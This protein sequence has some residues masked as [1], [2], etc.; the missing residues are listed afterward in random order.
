M[1]IRS[2]TPEDIPNIVEL[3]RLSLGERLMPK[4]IEFWNWKH[5]LNPFGTSKVLIAIDGTMIIGVRAFM[6]WHWSKENRIYKAV[7]A[8]D[9][10]THPAHQG[11]GIFK[12]LTLQLVEQC[13]QEGVDFIFNTPNKISKP[14]YL[15]MGWMT[16]GRMK[17]Y[18]K[19]V[20]PWRAKASNFDSL[21]SLGDSVINFNDEFTKDSS[22]SLTTAVST[23]FLQWRY[24]LNPNINYYVFSDG[25]TK[26]SYLTIFRL[27]P[28]RFGMEF[29]IC[30]NFKTLQCDDHAY[31]DHLLKVIHASGANVVSSS[32]STRLFPEI[33]LRVSPEITT[34]PLSFDQDFLK[35]NF[36]KP[37]LG[38]LEVF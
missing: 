1:I 36:W 6:F 25:K 15:K 23:E 32:A 16:N 33:G 18:V 13:R 28:N 2:A 37:S 21:Y 24:R 12:K 22:P 35:F 38:D 20:F 3:T 30:D 34:Y 26:P 31:R 27:K 29:R 4:S 7:R 8:V 17:L 9:T 5:T 11:R 10:A 19:P 14:G